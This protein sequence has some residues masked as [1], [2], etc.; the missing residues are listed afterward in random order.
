MN[1]IASKRKL[2]D[3]HSVLSVYRALVSKENTV[4]KVT[5]SRFCIPDKEWLFSLVLFADQLCGL[6]S[7]LFRAFLFPYG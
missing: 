5:I 7:F 1:F 6:D 2:L 3:I 4:S